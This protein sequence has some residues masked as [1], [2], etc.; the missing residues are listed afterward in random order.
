MRTGIS[1]SGKNI[2]VGWNAY[3]KNEGVVSSGDITHS[4]AAEYIDVDLTQN[5]K[6]IAFNINLFHGR[7]GFGDI[8]ECYV[9]LMAVK[10]LNEKVKLYNP[11][12]CFFSHNLKGMDKFMN[13]GYINVEKRILIFDGSGDDNTERNW[14]KY[15]E[16]KQPEFSLMDY[17]DLLTK[18]QN[19]EIVNDKTDAEIILILDKPSSDN[20]VSLIDENFFMDK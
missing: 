14:Y 19:V 1:K 5:L 10:N 20:E 4:D 15:N 3:F 2:H 8:E 17:V 16:H 9:G 18:V 12:N 11:K 6:E 7:S 13:Y